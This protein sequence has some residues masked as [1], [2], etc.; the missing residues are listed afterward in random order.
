MCAGR[1]VTRSSANRGWEAPSCR[2]SLR[3]QLHTAGA[4][5]PANQVRS[6]GPNTPPTTPCQSQAWGGSVH[7]QPTPPNPRMLSGPNPLAPASPLQALTEAPDW[8]PPANR[9]PPSPRGPSGTPLR[10][11]T[12]QPGTDTPAPL[13]WGP[14]SAIS[15]P[16]PGPARPGDPHGDHRRPHS[17]EPPPNSRSTPSAP[18]WLRPPSA[19]GATQQLPPA[20]LATSGK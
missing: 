4:S 1:R 14:I 9:P 17:W 11:R 7:P 5:A 2:F 10:L 3:H 15:E 6:Q 12:P 8:G 19:T 13:P 18:T 16:F 20:P